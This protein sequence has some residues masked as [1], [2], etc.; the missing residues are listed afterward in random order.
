MVEGCR[1]GLEEL[2]GDFMIIQHSFINIDI[3]SLIW[4]TRIW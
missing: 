1:F 3:Y 4:I 2:W